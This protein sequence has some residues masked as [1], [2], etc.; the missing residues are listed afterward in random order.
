MLLAWNRTTGTNV[1]IEPDLVSQTLSS[2]SLDL[3]NVQARRGVVEQMAGC[4]AELVSKL[5]ALCVD[6]GITIQQFLRA[7]LMHRLIISRLHV[8]I[9]EGIPLFGSVPCDIRLRHIATRT[10]A[11]V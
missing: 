4:P 7:G 1:G 3:S 9:G 11:G 5:A 10:Y 8:L 2:R 6:D